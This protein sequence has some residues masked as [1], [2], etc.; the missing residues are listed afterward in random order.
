MLLPVLSIVIV[1]PLP[2]EVKV[3]DELLVIVKLLIVELVLT[4]MDELV[5]IITSSPEPGTP[6]GFQL[7]S[8]FQLLFPPIQV[9]VAPLALPTPITKS[10]QV[11]KRKANSVVFRGLFL[12]VA[13]LGIALRLRSGY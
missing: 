11:A 2:E 6:N 13:S 3:T 5:L 8:V 1:L 7:A 10:K 12:V 4:V 9:L